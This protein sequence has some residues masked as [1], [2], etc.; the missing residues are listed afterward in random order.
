MLK[1]KTVIESWKE[2]EFIDEFEKHDYVTIHI[3]EEMIF[4]EILEIKENS[5]VVDIEREGD[6]QEISLLEIDYIEY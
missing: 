6:I 5:I 1:L 2:D 3:E 4:G